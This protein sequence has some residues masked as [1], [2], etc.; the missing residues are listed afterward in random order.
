MG[1][2]PMGVFLAFRPDPIDRRSSARV[3][4]NE[5][6][7]PLPVTSSTTYARNQ[8]AAVVRVS[9]VAR[10]RFCRRQS[11]SPRPPRSFVRSNC[12]NNEKRARSRTHGKSASPDPSFVRTRPIDRPIDRARAGTRARDR[13]THPPYPF[14]DS[15]GR[16]SKIKTKSSRSA[17]D[18]S[19]DRTHDARV[20]D[21]TPHVR[22][23]VSQKWTCF[24]F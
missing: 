16:D 13:S 5:E 17:I 22:L 3:Y 19:I 8:P 20:S 14:P 1:D 7:K 10:A 24:E 21:K 12:S 9:S 18:R 23:F 15:T 4:P 2:D 6:K 11:S